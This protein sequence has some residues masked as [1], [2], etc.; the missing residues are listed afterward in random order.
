MKKM[1]IY[2]NLKLIEFDM[3]ANIKM[4]LFKVHRTVE[5]AIVKVF[6]PIY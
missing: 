4:N 5:N 3:L 6:Y 2:A 1:D